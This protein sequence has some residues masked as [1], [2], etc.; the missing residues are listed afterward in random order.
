MIAQKI[1]YPISVD[2]DVSRD[3]NKIYERYIQGEKEVEFAEKVH[4]TG[5]PVNE[6]TINELKKI[7]KTQ[8]VEYNL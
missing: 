2:V 6:K 8:N 7:A 4:T 3:R 5:I 1:G